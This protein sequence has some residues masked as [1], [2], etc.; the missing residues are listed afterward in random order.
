MDFEFA[1][2]L[3]EQQWRQVTGI[4]ELNRRA[5]RVEI[6]PEEACETFSCRL[7]AEQRVE[8]AR[9]ADVILSGA[10]PRN[11]MDCAVHERH[12]QGR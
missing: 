8:L 3:A 7:F 6:A 2:V 12:Q 5:L 4:D 9:G 11:R 1:V 10:G